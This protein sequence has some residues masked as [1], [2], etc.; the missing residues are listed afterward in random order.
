MAIKN[1]NIADCEKK[2]Y[3]KDF[4]QMHYKRFVRHGDPLIT[5][6]PR[7][8]LT[9]SPAYKSWDHAKQRTT[10]SNNSNYKNYGGRGITMCQRWQDSFIEFLED[11]GQRPEG[12]S[13]DRID[14]DGNYEP[15]NCRWATRSL[16]ARNQRLNRSSK[17]GHRGVI[18]DKANTK[19]RVMMQING[20]QK[21]FGR[22]SNLNEAIS[23]RKELELAHWKES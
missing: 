1:C 5:K 17:S 11:M 3:N 20:K 9:D 16:Q 18:W 19:W 22:F 10:N 8:R 2:S 13:L 7:H 23:I 12:T 14:P 15:S 21:T 4:C 6:Q